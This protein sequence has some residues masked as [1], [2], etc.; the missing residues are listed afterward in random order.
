M[1]LEIHAVLPLLARAARLSDL[2]AQPSRF[3][4]VR[5]WITQCG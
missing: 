5:E 4:T 1:C 2:I 3:C